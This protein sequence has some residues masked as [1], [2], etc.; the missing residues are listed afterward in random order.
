MSPDPAP[1]LV[2]GATG[3][4]GGATARAL[5]AAGVPVRALVRD[6]ATG[7]A[8]AVEAL[9]A[10]LV[11]G[12]LHDRE[13]VIRAA[14]GARAVFSVQMPAMTGDAFDFEGEITQG[15][16]LI[17]GAKA[18]GVPQFVHTSVSGAGRHTETPGWAEGRWASLEA[19]LGAKSAIQDRVREAGFPHWTLIK[20]GFFMENF[21]P[22][23]AFLFPRGIEGGIVS[24]LNPA[25]RLSLVA[26][27]D[28]GRAAAAAIT[29]PERF[30]GVE[31][32]LASDYLSMTEIA[33]ALSRALS[34]ELSA[35]DMTEEQAR[36]AGMPGMG[37][38][39]EWM[40][41][42]GQP[43]RPEYAREFGIPLTSFEEWA[44]EHMRA[45]A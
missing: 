39:H 26:V 33:A 32:E 27:E 45:A 21:L 7:R 28:I 1:V 25:T 14:E 17:E 40:N 10:E 34:T 2:T 30:D 15:V 13:S 18:A 42:A 19:T 36:A 22:S 38:G 35:P 29:T 20:P 5:L 16:N 23:M 12:D 37:A 31:L 11:T 9:G 41:V 8:K 24:V 44:Q 4:Q 6:P 43:A 3:R